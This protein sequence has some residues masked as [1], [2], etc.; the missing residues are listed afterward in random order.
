MNELNC[1][2]SACVSLSER[3]SSEKQKATAR[4]CRFYSSCDPVMV[5]L[6]GT[7]ETPGEN[8]GLRPPGKNAGLGPEIRSDSTTPRC[9]HTVHC[10]Y[11]R[12]ILTMHCNLV[13]DSVN[14]FHSWPKESLKIQRWEKLN[15][16]LNYLSGRQHFFRSTVLQNHIP[17]LGKFTF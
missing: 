14:P 5:K 2:C 15:L 9:Q 11:Q 13:L 17:P 7:V 1:V 8:A 4:S 6:P 16:V 12:F 3:D 10:P